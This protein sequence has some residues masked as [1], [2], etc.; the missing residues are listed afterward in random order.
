MLPFGSLCPSFSLTGKTYVYPHF[1]VTL[2]F[3]LPPRVSTGRLCT[4]CT[5]LG[6]A[7]RHVSPAFCFFLAS[8]AIFP[9]FYGS[10]SVVRF[11]R[12]TQILGQ[13]SI[14]VV[15]NSQLTRRRHNSLYLSWVSRFL[16]SVIFGFPSFSSLLVDQKPYSLWS[17][18][19]PIAF[20]P[21]SE[22]ISV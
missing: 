14:C 4:I 20:M 9:P 13:S 22:T 1:F 18:K 19:T 12:A 5:P 7:V 21:W 17:P 8:P 10:T 11:F 6:I 2:L 15:F 16:K 3:Y